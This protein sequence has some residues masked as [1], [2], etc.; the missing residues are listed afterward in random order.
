[1]K[2]LFMGT[3][4]FAMAILQALYESGEEIVGAVTQ[5][6]RPK[7]RGY[8]LIP[9]PVK[10]FAEEH[11]IPVYQP[12]R[13][14]DGEFSATL[15][16]L[17]PDMI[18]V[19]AYGKILPPYILSCPP[20]GCINAHASILPKYRGA[21]P[22][23]RAVMDGETESGV[24]AMYMDE[25]LDTGDMILCEKITIDE[26]DN[27]ETVHDKLAEAGCR[28]ILEVVR[29]AKQGDLPRVKQDDTAST[30][31]PKI[32]KEDRWIDF[33]Q[34]ARRVHDKIRALSPFPR[35]VTFLPDGKMLQI[36]ASKM[37]S[38][39]ADAP[40]GTVT[41]A[42]KDGFSV[43]CSDGALLITE[44]IPEGRGKMRAA[45]FVRGRGVAAGERLGKHD[46]E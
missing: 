5:P 21:A 12:E 9:P 40:A 14:R 45:D 22:I 32:E 25:G 18:V 20:K 1:M 8:K 37:T 44:V 39:H 24:T 35:A 36:T 29:L 38:L 15:D 16:E 41:D 17:S 4:D 46:D 30:Y 31:A 34:S 19:A 26:D 7:G 43:T 27:F 28:A 23:Q 13:L 11:G 3:P 10:V 6:D 2:I 33:S 42:G